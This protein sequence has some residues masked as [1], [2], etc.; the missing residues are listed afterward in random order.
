MHISKSLIC[1]IAVLAA[2]IDRAAGGAHAQSAQPPA[3]AGDAPTAA[4]IALHGSAG[5]TSSLDFFSATSL[6]EA[7]AAADAK[8]VKT[9]FLDI[10]SASGVVATKDAVVRSI[11]NARARGVRTVAVVRNAGGVSALIALA[12][13]RIV[14]LPGAGFGG[15]PAP[16]SGVRADPQVEKAV[17]GL[18]SHIADSESS[19]RKFTAV[20]ADAA[21]VT[22]RSALLSRALVEHSVQ[23]W[24]LKNGEFV[25]AA[26]KD[27]EATRLDR[28]GRV[29]A[30]G[31]NELVEL[32]LATSAATLADAMH[33]FSTDPTP[34]DLAKSMELLQGRIKK[35]LQL[36]DVDNRKLDELKELGHSKTKSV[37]SS[38]EASKRQLESKKAA[39]VEE[40]RK[41]L[42]AP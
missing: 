26:P 39:H 6:D 13:E 10:D 5:F 23:I 19:R 30:L 40:L 28:E 21:K 3:K 37:Q 25:E 7:I 24:R 2:G 20:D 1:W 8:S 17:R 4:V 22:G 34:I 14:V 35:A 36:I 11:L 9:L 27:A 12:C 38:R 15:E 41:L 31:G 16:A 33:A 42:E 32:S 29:L 18:I